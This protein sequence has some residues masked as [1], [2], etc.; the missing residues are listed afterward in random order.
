MLRGNITFTQDQYQ[1]LQKLMLS[2]IL[3]TKISTANNTSLTF[4][5]S[6]DELEEILD[7]TTPNA[8]NLANNSELRQHVLKTL[9]AWRKN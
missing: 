1:F 4:T 2:P 9:Q 6:E 5:L 8:N 3:T 7:A